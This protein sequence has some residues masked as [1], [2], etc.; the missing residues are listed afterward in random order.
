[1]R[2]KYENRGVEGGFYH[3]K[4]GQ[5]L[6]WSD[7]LGAREVG[8]SKMSGGGEGVKSTGIGR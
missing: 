5:N 1:M 6:V 3:A 4:L 2:N 8:R 7:R